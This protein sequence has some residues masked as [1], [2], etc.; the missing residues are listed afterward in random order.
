[1]KK[2]KLPLEMANGVMVRSLDELRENWDLEKIVGYFGDGRLVTWLNDRYYTDL[3]ERVQKIT[4][5]GAEAQEQLCAVFG[6]EFK[7]DEVVDAEAVAERKRKLDLVRQYTSDD[8]VLKNIDHVAF[9]QEDLADLLD[10]D[11]EKIYLC[12]GKFVIPLGIRN[13]EYVGLGN[14]EIYIGK[15]EWIDFDKLGIKFRDVKFD[16]KYAEVADGSPDKIYDEA[17]ALENDEFYD[18]AFEKFKKL[19]DMDDDRGLFWVGKCYDNCLGVERNLELAKEYYEK[20]VEKGNSKAANNLGNLYHYDNGLEKNYKKAIEYYQK[21]VDGGSKKASYNLAEVY[22]RGGAGV[23]QNYEKAF[24]YYLRAD[25]DCW[26]MQSVGWMYEYG[27]GVGANVEKAIEYYQKA[28]DLGHYNEN[29]QNDSAYRCALLYDKRGYSRNDIA[30]CFRKYDAEMKRKLIEGMVSDINDFSVGYFSFSIFPVPGTRAET[31]RSIKPALQRLEKDMLDKSDG[32]HLDCC[33]TYCKYIKIA[34]AA[35]D[36]NVDEGELK[37]IK[38]KIRIRIGQY[39]SNIPSFSVENV[40]SQF[41]VEFSYKSEGIFG[42]TRYGY[43]QSSIRTAKENI[44]NSCKQYVN[45][46]RDDVNSYIFSF[47]NVLNGIKDHICC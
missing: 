14:A 45:D 37:A 39:R 8:E 33:D 44:E 36:V 31:A 41:E 24:E 27:Q 23:E 1:M 10:E 29:R 20:A 6:M 19:A 21:A 46:F 32:F 47:R 34:G 12:N 30:N 3:A 11:V 9:N 38:E 4:A 13:K 43:L 16:A 2:I 18:K 7:Q 35:C 42:P 15:D 25:D 28:I 26:A 40:M 17:M 22:Y 5:I